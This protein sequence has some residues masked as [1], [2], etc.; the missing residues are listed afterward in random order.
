MIYTDPTLRNLTNE[1]LLA[2]LQHSKDP[3]V[4]ELLVRLAL[5]MDEQGE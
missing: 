4:R 2:Q 1:E 5:L 3:I